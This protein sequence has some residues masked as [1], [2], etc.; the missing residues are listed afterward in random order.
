[1]NIKKLLNLRPFRHSGK[2]EVRQMWILGRWC[3]EDGGEEL[4]ESVWDL[5]AS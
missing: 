1:M 3:G 4:G 2:K 5:S